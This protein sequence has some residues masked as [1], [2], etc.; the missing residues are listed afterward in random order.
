MTPRSAVQFSLWLAV[1]HRDVFNEML[2]RATGVR[3]GSRLGRLGRIGDSMDLAPVNVSVSYV[4]PGVDTSAPD[5]SSL[6]TSS[7]DLAPI[8]VTSQY[9]D[10][11]GNVI[12]ATTAQQMFNLPAPV[13]PPIVSAPDLASVNLNPNDV[14]GAVNDPSITQIDPGAS[15]AATGGGS[16]LSDL[17]SGI[18]SVGASLLKSV[19][20][21]AAGLTNPTTIKSLAGVA[22][23]YFTTQ[24]QATALQ[25]QLARANAGMSPA[26]I[27]YTRDANGNLVPVMANPQTGTIAYNSQGQP[28]YV[29]PRLANGLL[30][31]AT[32]GISSLSSLTP[33]LPIVI[34]GAALLFL[35]G[36]LGSSPAPRYSR[37][38]RR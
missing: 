20:T 37:G 35:I 38:T 31:N 8:D 32:A 7:T 30:P 3:A 14:A 22:Q 1:N 16:F 5:F 15:S 6:D 28:Y 13:V 12:D 23:S 9:I 18:A 36:G 27:T 17:G 10:P 26:P 19:G 2:R 11:S 24:A 21:V 25:T 33:Y 29:T 4:T 34:G